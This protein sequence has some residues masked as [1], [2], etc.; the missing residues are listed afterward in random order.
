MNELQLQTIV[1]L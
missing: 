1:S